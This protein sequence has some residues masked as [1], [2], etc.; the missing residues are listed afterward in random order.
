MKVMKHNPHSA[1]KDII[2]SWYKIDL[3]FGIMIFYGN[4]WG[5]CFDLDTH[6]E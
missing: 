4:G 3:P 2:G 6:F 1:G 5:D